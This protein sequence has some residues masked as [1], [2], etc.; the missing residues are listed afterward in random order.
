MKLFILLLL[1]TSCANTK[2]NKTSTESITIDPVEM[3]DVVVE[4]KELTDSN[5]I[6]FIDEN[7]GYKKI[8]RTDVYTMREEEL[9]HI[10]LQQLKSLQIPL[11]SVEIMDRLVFIE[12]KLTLYTNDNQVY[13]AIFRDP[14]ENQFYFTEFQETH[15]ISKISSHN[16]NLNIHDYFIFITNTKN[17][18]RLYL[19]PTTKRYFIAKFYNIFDDL[20]FSYSS[21]VQVTRDFSVDKIYPY[22]DFVPDNITSGGFYG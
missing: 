3:V 6:N 15:A 8:T 12:G 22:M 19:D 20:Q 1:L 4:I 5:S 10:T 18:E 21:K 9:Q 13:K 14:K 16:T 2:Q 17:T 11:D 7:I